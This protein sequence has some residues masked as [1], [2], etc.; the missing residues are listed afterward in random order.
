MAGPL[1]THQPHI[2]PRLRHL[3][4]SF[5]PYIYATLIQSLKCHQEGI[6][7]A[8]APALAQ[9]SQSGCEG[10]PA[11]LPVTHSRWWLLPRPRAV[12]H[13]KF[14]L[15]FFISTRGV[16][17]GGAGRRSAWNRFRVD[18]GSRWA[19]ALLIVQAGQAVMSAFPAPS[20]ATVRGW[21]RRYQWLDRM[22]TRSLGITWG[23]GLGGVVAS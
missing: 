9:P 13:E 21:L 5:P 15:R 6:S 11:R 18:A 3:S 12:H 22:V 16:W 19:H 8:H 2:T 20:M 23:G 1:Y 14:H 4:A 10:R 7:H 17:A